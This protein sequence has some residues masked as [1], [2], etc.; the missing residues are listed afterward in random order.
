MSFTSYS[1]NSR[2]VVSDTA[3]RADFSEIPLI[4]LKAPKEDLIAQ[5]TDA[6]A[7]VGFFYV[8]DHD[9]P[10]GVIDQ[11]FQTA[12]EFFSQ[13]L[14]RKNEINYKKSRILRGYEPP[15]E[16]RTD[17]TRKPDLNEAFNWGYEK[18]LDPLFAGSDDTPGPEWKDNPMSG[19]NAWPDMPGFQGS[20]RAYYVQ[21]LQLA[22]NMIRLFAE[23]LHL[24]PNFFD[25]LVSTPGAMGRLIHYPPQPAS[26][27]DALGI[28][29]H[30][31]IECF[32]ILCQGSVPALQILNAGGEWIEAP[33]IPGTFVV[34]IGDLLARWTN[35]RFVSTVHRVWNV[36]GQERYSIPFFFGVNYDATVSTLDSC[37]AEG[38]KSK[39][40]P[41]QA[42]EYVWKR[43]S[44]S[45]VDQ[46]ELR[47]QGTQAAA[48]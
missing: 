31:D 7:R 33:P 23:V 24:P 3:R 10:Q 34:N 41:I 39:Y 26:D 5:L 4:S 43:L 6:C 35:D 37:L 45:R 12:T 19:P 9:V 47:V 8:K 22:R 25:E 46:K 44:V 17:E 29:A 36:T 21:V 14:A 18:S 1:G 38:E 48:A 32:T 16:V 15:A 27:P 30:T 40:E 28:G 42:G 13:D 20:I 11:L 2:S